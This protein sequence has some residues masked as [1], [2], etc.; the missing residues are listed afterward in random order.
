VLAA[1]GTAGSFA[2]S[3]SAQDIVLNSVAI[4]FVFELDDFLYVAIVSRKRREA[5]EAAPAPPMSPLSNKRHRRIVSVAAW[6]VF[7][8]DSLFAIDYYA[9]AVSP[10]NDN[11]RV[12]WVSFYEYK[13]I[14]TRVWII[15]RFAV[16]AL[17][18]IALT[19]HPSYVRVYLAGGARRT[20]MAL[21]FAAFLVVLLAMLYLAFFFNAF[22]DYEFGSIDPPPELYGCFGLSAHPTYRQS[23]A[24]LNLLEVN[25]TNSTNSTIDSVGRRLALRTSRSTMG[26]HGQDCVLWHLDSGLRQ[27]I[28]SDSSAMTM[29]CHMHQY[30][31]RMFS[32]SPPWGGPW[33]SDSCPDY[34]E[35]LATHGSQ[36][37]FG[38]GRDVYPT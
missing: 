6:V 1:L 9:K 19:Y 15:M 2:V 16:I 28:A 27:T 25:D 31:W 5:Y 36:R 18:Q 3:K 30:I 38:L 20:R 14:E 11:G 12:S 32:D 8:I 34:D 4:S 22:M 37:L 7:V 13:Y 23:L 33:G 21:S 24:A 10:P 35:R 26:G 17:A 29:R